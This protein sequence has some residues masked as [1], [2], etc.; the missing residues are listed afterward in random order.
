MLTRISDEVHRFTINYHRQ[1]R[2]KGSLESV[3]TNVN[4]IGETRKKELLKKYGSLKKM[5]EA[6]ISDLEEILPTNVA[7]DLH[8]YLI[9]LKGSEKNE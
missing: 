8:D 6:S 1:I 9:S 4:G 7:R 5:T 3:L 2:S